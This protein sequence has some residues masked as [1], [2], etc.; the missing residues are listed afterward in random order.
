MASSIRAGLFCALILAVAGCFETKQV[1]TLNP[2]GSGKVVM[3]TLMA[4]QAMMM[5]AATSKE[6]APDS[7]EIAKGMAV[8]MISRST[9]V[10]AWS[11]VSYEVAKDNRVHL[12]ATAYFPDYSKI[13][14]EG[15]SLMEANW[16]KADK[17]MVLE[18]QMSS[19]G[20]DGEKAEPAPKALTDKEVDDLLKQKRQEWAMSKAMMAQV[21]N[22]L[23]M[24][25]TFVLPGKVVEANIFEKTEQGVRLSIEGKKIL[26]AMDKIVA[27]DKLMKDAIKAGKDPVKDGPGASDA[28]QEAMF[29]GKGPIRA[30]VSGDIKPLF[31]YKAEVAKAKAAQ[32]A[33]L[34]KLGIEAAPQEK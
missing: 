6:S 27:D 9:G 34:K 17:D 24:D 11:D 31:D 25:T 13:K 14:I 10:D 5:M 20:P 8:G 18:V 33:M 23:K 12:T 1:I 15:P 21:F 4:S 26:A 32:P 22:S 30:R 2:D 3:D 7:N 16:T 28:M 29:G 19:K